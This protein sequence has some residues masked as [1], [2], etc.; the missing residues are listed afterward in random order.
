M[1]KEQK[2]DPSE[3]GK[4]RESVLKWIEQKSN[5]KIGAPKKDFN[6][7]TNK[8]NV[9][10]EI[11]K[12]SS[13]NKINNPIKAKIKYFSIIFIL[14]V[15]SLPISFQTYLFFAKPKN[16]ITLNITRLFP[17]PAAFVNYNQISYSQ[18]LKQVLALDK[19][20]QSVNNDSID[21]NLPPIEQSDSRIME[22]LIEEEML[23]QF[24]KQFSIAIT[25]NEIDMELERL[26][27]L[28]GKENFINQIEEKYSWNTDEFKEFILEP[29][30]LKNKLS[31]FLLDHPKNQQAKIM[32]QDVLMKLKNK[33]DVFENIAQKYSQDD[34]ARNGGQIGYFELS[35]MNSEIKNAIINLKVGEISEIIKT[36]F[37][38]HILRID[39]ILL[40][41]K[42]EPAK[43]KISQILIKA[44]DLNE[45]MEEFKKKSRIRVLINLNN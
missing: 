11:S 23:N 29:M 7:T 13:Y 25:K 33:E 40:D 35:D 20:Y 16:I 36:K 10:K 4:M 43:V 27:E 37:G 19:F 17:F 34:S 39:E 6:Q 30:L 38:F 18:W 28:F 22:R 3:I 32:A 31:L 5:S 2:I 12:N 44:I 1:E 21:L 42:G 14:L 45:H 8:I 24:A 9:A 41:D 26:F 15:I